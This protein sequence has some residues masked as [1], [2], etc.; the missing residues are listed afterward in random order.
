M[1]HFDIDA[2]DLLRIGDELNATPK[3]VKLA[4]SRALDRTATRLRVLSE[5]GLKSELGLRRV[6]YL[7]KRLKSIRLRA[8]GSDGVRLWYG[9]N[10]MPVSSFAGTPVK[11]D[12]GAS[13]RGHEFP[14]AFVARSGPKGRRT[15]FKRTSKNRLHIEEQLLP[16]KDQAET[17]VEDRIFPDLEDIF[18]PIFRRELAAR[19]KFKLG[20]A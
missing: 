9:L 17:F 1:I 19:V 15:V 16:I 7:R 6:S 3:Q 10:D 13:F 8:A 14:G 11:T 2:D 18:W 20:E 12:S 4:L 5:R